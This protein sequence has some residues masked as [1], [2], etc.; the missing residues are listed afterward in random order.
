LENAKKAFQE[1]RY[2][3]AR[4]TA[5]DT[6]QIADKVIT[7]S[8]VAEYRRRAQE[9]LTAKIKKSEGAV[10][11]A[12]AAITEQTQTKVPQFAPEL[13][14]LATSALATAESALAKKEYDSA[15]DAAQQ[16]HD[17]LR[18]AIEKTKQQN[19]AQTALVEAVQQI[20]KAVVIERE[21]GVLI[22]ISG[23][24]FATTSTRLND[25]FFPTFMKL[26]SILQ[27]DEFKDYVVKIEGHSDSLGDAKTN[28]ALSEKR[29]NSIK[30]FLIDKGKVTTKRLTAVGLGESQPIDKNSEE[31][32][33]RVD[34]IISKAP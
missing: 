20:P 15:I 18:R 33:R 13:Y 16:S 23:N 31:K 3:E 12:K 27:Q 2:G 11:S 22:R 34:I 25:G 21:E 8:E 7:I 6:E 19:S 4:Q 1:N 30:T 28:Q 9:E 24:L 32:N 17:Y 5:E 26:A 10:A 14:E 29:A